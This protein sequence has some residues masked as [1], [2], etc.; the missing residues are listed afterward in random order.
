MYHWC[1]TRLD[2][3]TVTWV[4]NGSLPPKSLKMPTN[5]GTMKAISASS[6]PSAKVS[7]TAG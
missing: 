7:T 5:T 3:F 4:M 2:R 1:V 6:M